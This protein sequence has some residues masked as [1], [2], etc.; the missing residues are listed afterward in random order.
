MPHIKKPRPHVLMI[1]CDSTTPLDLLQGTVQIQC[2]GEAGE[3]R[4][5]ALVR[6]IKGFFVETR[7]D[8]AIDRYKRGSR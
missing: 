7:K 8:T 5:H 1:E 3:L 4:Y 2:L 6:Q